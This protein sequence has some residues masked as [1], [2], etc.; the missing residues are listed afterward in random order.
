MVLA[1]RQ[2]RLPYVQA[3]IRDLIR[4]VYVTLVHFHCIGQ[5]DRLLYNILACNRILQAINIMC[6]QL[7]KLVP[8][9]INVFISITLH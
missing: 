8:D 4:I 5:V 6:L 9:Y 1:L 3:V 2:L 7:M